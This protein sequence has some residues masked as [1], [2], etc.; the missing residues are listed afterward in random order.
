MTRIVLKFQP[1]KKSRRSAVEIGAQSSPSL[2][3]ISHIIVYTIL[4][5][6][7]EH[8]LANKRLSKG[9]AEYIEPF[10]IELEL[11]ATS[12]MGLLL[13]QKIDPEDIAQETIISAVS[14]WNLF[15]NDPDSNEQLWAWLKTILINEIRENY[16]R[17][18]TLSRDMNREMS[19]VSDPSQSC[20]GINAY[21]QSDVASPQDMALRRERLEKLR[22]AL[23][24]LPVDEQQAVVG[25]Y[26]NQMKI[27]E[28]AELLQMS[29]KMAS[30]RVF[31]GLNK[32]LEIMGDDDFWASR[33][34]LKPA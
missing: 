34:G 4:G 6:R 26:I 20:A 22:S 5:S 27:K 32:L 9:A 8:K 7:L 24:T 13:R 17:Y 14:N 21:A 29:E 11:L 30:D 28:I 25:R 10:R 16:R 31:R 1:S 15:R 33:A 12:Q 23:R 2:G 18:T 19:L 3:K